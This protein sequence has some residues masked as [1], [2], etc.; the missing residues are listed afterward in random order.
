MM[1]LKHAPVAI[2]FLLT[3]ASVGY[4]QATQTNEDT[5]VFRMQVWGEIVK[6]F[7]ARIRSYVDLRSEMEKGLPP[8]TSTSDP[9]EIRRIVS[10]LST[11]MQ[12]AR[13]KARQGDI[14]TP[15]IS[16]QFKKVL[17]PELNAATREAIGDDNPGE[18]SSRI[19]RIYP[20]RRPVST[21]PP[22]ILAALPPL[23]DGIEYRF[24]G[25]HLILLDTKSR[26]IIDRIPYAIQPR[27]TEKEH[28]KQK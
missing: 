5:P 12:T 7:S 17:G 23:P 21:V 19:N 13:A 26:M 18:F 14:F 3:T 16:L 6:D 15:A 20:D 24:L 25:R 4:G 28:V 8:L 22:N 2:A 11:R 9:A 10:T 27:F 1:R